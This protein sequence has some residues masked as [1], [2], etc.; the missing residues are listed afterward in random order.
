MMVF[1]FVLKPSASDTANG[2]HSPAPVPNL[3]QGVSAS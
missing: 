1:S 2:L 3:S